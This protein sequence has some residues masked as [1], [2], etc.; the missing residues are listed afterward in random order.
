MPRTKMTYRRC[1]NIFERSL[2]QKYIQKYKNHT[3]DLK[4][5]RIGITQKMFTKEDGT[6]Q[7]AF[8]LDTSKYQDVKILMNCFNLNMDEAADLLQNE[9]IDNVASFFANGTVILKEIRASIIAAKRLKIQ[10]P[11]VSDE[12]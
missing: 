2:A 6:L 5:E 1:G 7:H 12:E 3:L 4:L 10:H 9:S 8:V 11:C